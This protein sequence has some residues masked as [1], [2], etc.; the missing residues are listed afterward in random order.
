MLEVESTRLT[1]TGGRVHRVDLQSRIQTGRGTDDV[2]RPA[3]DLFENAADVLAE[4]SKAN[5]LTT[6]EEQH[7]DEQRRPPGHCEIGEEISEDR[8][9]PVQE[10]Q[11]R[12]E[13]AT[14]CHFPE[15]VHTE[16]CHAIDGEP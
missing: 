12:H 4:N 10:R 8:G 16:R 14:Q 2:N 5:Q 11:P 7:A 1:N 3:L 15:R 13:Y 9:E 6:T